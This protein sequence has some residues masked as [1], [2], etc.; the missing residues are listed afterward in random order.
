M[1]PRRAALAQPV[2]HVGEA[3]EIGPGGLPADG[4]A[5]QRE[6]LL[7]LPAPLEQPRPQDQDGGA[8]RLEPFE[9]GERL[10]RRVHP[11]PLQGDLEQRD[12]GARI[13]RRQPAG[14][15]QDLEAAVEI[16]RRPAVPNRCRR[17]SAWST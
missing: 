7:P 6:G 2:L 17:I 4:F 10:L 16:G 5:H 8:F 13:G 1:V 14:L 11:F 3:E 15:G 12:Q 9:V